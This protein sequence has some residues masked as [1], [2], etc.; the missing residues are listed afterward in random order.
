MNEK[1]PKDGF[2]MNSDKKPVGFKSAPQTQLEKSYEC[3]LPNG[4]V[5]QTC[6]TV[7]LD[8]YKSE[9]GGQVLRKMAE[10]SHNFY[11]ELGKWLNNMP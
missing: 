1:T 6:I 10:S 2:I 8:K 7:T 5:I 11:L 9:D 3:V 4:S